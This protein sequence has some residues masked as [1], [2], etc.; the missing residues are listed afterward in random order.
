MQ[1]FVVAPGEAAKTLENLLKQKFP[2]GY[3]RKLFRKH[4]V[5]LNGQR[6]KPDHTTRSGDLIQLY[7]PFA[8]KSSTPTQNGSR[9]AIAM[10][11]E[12]DS[13]LVIDKP[14]GLTVGEAK[15]VGKAESLAGIIEKKYREASFHPQLAHRLDRDTSGLILL[16]KN[17]RALAELEN[18]FESGQIAK[19]YLCMTHGHL[20]SDAGK[21][22]YPLPG[23]DGKLVRAVTRYRVIKRFSETTL[24]RVNPETGRLHQIRLHFAKLGYPVVMDDR[25]GD[26]SFNKR[27]RKRYGLKRQFLHA[28]KLAIDFGGKRHRWT[29]PLAADLERIINQLEAD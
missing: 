20:P 4:G 11:Y 12:D 23:R 6:A 19:E 17:E 15:T 21:I 10:I 26:F 16:A 24:V 9:R 29:A 7:I 2:I 5:R 22:D 8:A 25:H 28:A 18:G 27:F 3:V 1:E 14:A 13:L